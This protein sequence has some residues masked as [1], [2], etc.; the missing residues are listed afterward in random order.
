MKKGKLTVSYDEYRYSSSN[1]KGNKNEYTTDSLYI[2]RYSQEQ[3]GKFQTKC[4]SRRSIIMDS[5]G[6]DY[7]RYH[8]KFVLLT[9][10]INNH[11]LT[12]F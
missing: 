11:P 10:I 3:K 6:A 1:Q 7:R 12:I 9:E 2:T 5:S 4:H 8:C